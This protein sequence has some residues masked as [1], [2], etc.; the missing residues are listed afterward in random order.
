MTLHLIVGNDATH[1]RPDVQAWLD[2]HP[3]VV[4]HYTR[5]G[6]SWL[7]V[8]ERFFRH[9]TDKRLRHDRAEWRTT[10]GGGGLVARDLHEF[11]PLPGVGL[12]SLCEGRCVQELRDE[13]QFRQGVPISRLLADATQCILELSAKLL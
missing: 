3:R 5:T 8:V 6:A 7:N 2:K 4:M 11:N 10:L 13:A 1:N 9:I 12:D